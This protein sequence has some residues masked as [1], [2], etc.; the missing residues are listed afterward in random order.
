MLA[1]GDFMVML[2]DGQAHFLADGN[3][4][5]ADIGAAVNRLNGEVAALDP[6]PMGAVAAF[7]FFAGHEG[8]FPVGQLVEAVM[9]ADLEADIVEHE[10][11]S[12][13]SEIGGIA[14][15]RAGKIGLCLLGD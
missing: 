15:S 2:F 3:H 11:F 9:A 13:R 14:D 8:G 5:A 6:R 4:F 7:D 10:K 1:R 12:F